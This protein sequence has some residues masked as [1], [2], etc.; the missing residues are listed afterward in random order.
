MSARAG[1]TQSL[2]TLRPRL[3]DFCARLVA[4]DSRN[5]PGD[6]RAATALCGAALSS[7]PGVELR[8]VVARSSVVNLIVIVKGGSAGRRLVS[9]GHLD[10]GPLAAAE[11][12][13]IEPFGGV[14][15]DGKLFGPG[16]ADMKAG[17]AAGVFTL[18]ALSRHRESWSGEFVLTLV[19]DEGTGGHAGT[20]HVLEHCPEASGDAML[21]GDVGS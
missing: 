3:V 14:V 15:R 2:E 19:G 10:T 6:T 17:V 21:S 13:R 16:A 11:R 1:F 7:L 20:R 5:P 9:N 18:E 4:T 8:E 12:W